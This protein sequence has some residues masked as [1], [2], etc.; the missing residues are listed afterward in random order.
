[1]RKPVEMLGYY[2]PPPRGPSLGER[3]AETLR[4]FFIGFVAALAIAGLVAILIIAV[5]AIYQRLT[6]S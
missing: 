3:L 5:V 4:L 6:A 1:M 2:T